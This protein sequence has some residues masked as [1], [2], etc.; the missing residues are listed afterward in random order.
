V[1]ITRVLVAGAMVA[2]FAPLAPSAFAQEADS[3]RIAELERQIEAI[4]RELERQTLG[5][6]VVEA[7]SSVLGF[8]PAA[9]KVYRVGQGVSVGGYGETLY[10]NHS[11]ERED[12][13]PS[14]A[15]DQIDAL[16]AIVYVGY[17]FNDRLLF[18]SELE[19][20]HGSTDNAGSA[21]VEFA[22]IDYRLNDSF[23]LRGG[24]L[25]SPMG[26]VNELHE[27]PVFLGTERPFTESSIIPTTW[28]ENGVGAFGGNDDF[29][30]RVYVMN[31]LDGV[32]GGPSSAD[33]FSS[34]GLRGGRQKGSKALAE[35]LGVVARL[36]YLGSL[37]FILGGSAF[38]G[39]TGHGREF[40]GSMVEGTTLIWEGHAEY[41]ASGWDLRALVAG[42][43]VDDV[44]ALNELRGLEG[45]GSIGESMLGWYV[46]AGY[47]L[48][49]GLPS[50]HQLIPYARY[51]V[52]N[53]QG[54]VP[55]GFSTN[56]ANERTILSVGA[57]W[58]PVPQVV[59]KLDFQVHSN[60]AETGVNQLNV[61]LGYLF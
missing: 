13:A 12:G 23:G 45:N 34:I 60:E 61:A 43:R 7:D 40:D 16:R 47:D 59:T 51:E 37:G 26:F 17:K 19:F 32:G 41:K 25:L 21:S 10:E 18:N 55:E 52:V 48:L 27:P 24:L 46:Q 29:S 1:K 20:E 56:P 5:D 9:S 57:A 30:W 42:A 15:S 22:Y 31:S 44:A 58:K 33:G 4:T 49:R 38:R 2:T 14:G 35:D 11:Y 50:T 54:E 53:T 28:R 6:A 39:G 36:D 8:G 3:A